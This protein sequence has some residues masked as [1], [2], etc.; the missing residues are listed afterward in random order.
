MRAFTVYVGGCGIT[1]RCDCEEIARDLN[2]HLLPW[3]PRTSE[4]SA[5]LVF[6]V[7]RA[8]E[9]RR[10]RIATQ[11]AVIAHS[12]QWPYL[13]T[14]LQ[15]AVDEVMI[16]R[17]T[18]QAAVH[19]GVVAWRGSGILLPGSSGSGKTELVA[20]LVRRGAEYF[21]D[22]YALVDADGLVHPYPRALM[23][24]DGGGLQHPVLPARFAAQALPAGL[25]LSI[26]YQA[27]ATFQVERISHSEALLGLLRNTPHVLAEKPE[28]M[29]PLRAAAD[30]AGSFVG[31]RGEAGDAA[32]RILE[33]V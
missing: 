5:A 3:L 33:M 22:E 11:D 2:T 9:P 12:E 29:A 4:T 26:R 15:Q 31:T 23:V 17:L 7:T 28:I 8:A 20:E 6:S 30:R 18:G 13:F 10:F 24:R 19:A 1:I 32:Q 25:I 21:S 14:A 27:G 16:Q